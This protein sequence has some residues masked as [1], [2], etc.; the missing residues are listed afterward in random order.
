VTL[1]AHEGAWAYD[2]GRRLALVTPAARDAL[3]PVRPAP[4]AGPELVAAVV[5]AARA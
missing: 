4:P 5:G 1:P 3:A 2:A